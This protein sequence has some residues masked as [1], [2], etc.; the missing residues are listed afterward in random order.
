MT[1]RAKKRS[2]KTILKLPDLE[3]SPAPPRLYI[4]AFAR[5]QQRDL[6]NECAFGASVGVE[7][8]REYSFQNRHAP[9][10][11]TCITPCE[12]QK[13]RGLLLVLADK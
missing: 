5:S 9:L 11:L 10:Y 1:K 8:S 12:A 13:Q 2:P 7:S 6:G 4:R 3:N